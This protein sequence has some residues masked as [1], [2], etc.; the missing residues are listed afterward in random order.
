MNS[1]NI[2]IF[3]IIIVV[4]FGL[5]FSVGRQ[6]GISQSEKELIPLVDLAYPGPPDKIYSFRGIVQGIYGADIKLEIN[7]PD[8][9][10]PHLDGS[11][12][13]KEIRTARTSFATEFIMTELDQFSDPIITSI[14]LADIKVGDKIRVGSDQNIKD[15]QK[16]DAARITVTKSN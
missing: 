2:T 8:D 15:L 4:A 16:F 12:R 5:G 13:R 7:D 9:Y 14:S 10:L 1:K 6:Q 3:V 11:P